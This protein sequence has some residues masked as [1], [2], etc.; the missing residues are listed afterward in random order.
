[1][2]THGHHESVLLS[3]RW[4]TAENSA[5]YLLPW[6]KPGQALLDVGSGP[7]TITVDLARLVAPG[8]VTALE[9]TETVLA[10]TRAEA[11]RQGVELDYLVSDA[12]AIDAP[13]AR[14][15][16]VHAHQL[17]Q[18]V[19]DPVQVLREMRRVCRPGGIVAVRDGDYGGGFFWYPESPG[20]DEWRC[21][22]RK[23]A[24]HNGGQPDAGRRLLSWAL[25][26]GFTDVTPSCSTWLFATPP[27]REFWGASWAWRSRESDFARQAVDLGYA[28][29]ADL[30]RIS[31]AWLA[32]AGAPD[33]WMA[34]TSGEIIARP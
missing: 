33:G 9:A 18:H 5:A 15:D 20:L 1:M 13:D 29:P 8:R 23:V 2:Y 11:Q 26:A 12:H 25:A 34:V 3:H 24:R 4:R 28:T 32:W 27:D 16:I 6:L 31:D 19:H 10:L 30:Q 22:Y 17:L 21:L 14:F 7:G